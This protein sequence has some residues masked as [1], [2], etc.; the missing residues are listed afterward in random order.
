V[1]QLDVLLQR[2]DGTAVGLLARLRDVLPG[3]YTF[4]L[5]GR[6]PDGQLLPPG[7]YVLRV[8]AYPVEEGPPD[9][10][11]LSFTLR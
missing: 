3:R 6:G 4:G 2:A 9:R 8:I 5:T 7:N 10:R 11:R 1:Q